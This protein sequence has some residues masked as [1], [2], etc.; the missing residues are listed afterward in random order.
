MDRLYVFDTTLRDGEQSPGASLTS[1]EKF[2]IALQL[3]DLGVDVIEAGFPIASPDDLAAV[4]RIANEVKGPLIA[5]LAR[6]RPEDIDAAWE[7]LKDGENV[8]IHTFIST[9]DIH[10]Q[11]Q[12]RMTRD[13]ALEQAVDMV[14]RAKRYVS[15]VEFS[16][17]DATRSDWNFLYQMLEAVIEAGATTVNIPDTVGFITPIEFGQLVASIRQ[18]VKNIE[19]AVISVH[20]HNDLGM[21][22][23]NSLSAVLNGARQVE[24]T[25]NGIGERAGNAALEE[26]VMAT[27]TRPEIYGVKTGIDTKQI[28]KT[29]RLVSTLTGIVVQPNKAVVGSNAFAH[30]AGIHQDGL[31]KDRSTY[32]IMD[33]RDV[34]LSQSTLVL[35]KHSGRHALR[36]RFEELGYHLSDEELNRAFVRFK[37][38]ADKKKEVT[39]KDLEAILADEISQV[40][41]AY[42][43]AMLQVSCG[44][45]AVPTATVSLKLPNGDE[46]TEV[47]T[48][49]GPV[50]AS[51][52]AIAKIVNL[53]VRL[54]E[55]SVRSVTGGI[56]A[57]GEVSVRIES[58]NRTFHGRGADPDIIVASAKAYLNALNKAAAAPQEAPERTDLGVA[59]RVGV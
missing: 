18:H 21:A 46:R 39:T 48:G 30:E 59:G 32:E 38:I 5:G 51:Y 57:L 12:F 16:P 13:Q 20:C 4:R 26:I 52:Q 31:L 14:L 36:A 56:D 33:A 54:A 10:L 8:R 19:K 27:N 9:S 35:G 2:E 37:E 49:T 50:D 40:P 43:V 45:P 15:D 7:A 55:Y 6:C 11:H 24:C 17:M 44:Y 28:Y 22:V 58:G 29:S 47:A 25:I 42:Q 23:S 3:A 1:D 34:G 41:E 53:P